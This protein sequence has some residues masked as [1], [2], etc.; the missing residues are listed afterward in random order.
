ML[1]HVFT[2][3]DA[4]SVIPDLIRDRHDKHEL[5]AFLNY[6][7]AFYPNMLMLVDCRLYTT[8]WVD[9]KKIKTS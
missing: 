9:V 3:L 7:T 4:G 1:F 2:L 6:G 8:A 5:N